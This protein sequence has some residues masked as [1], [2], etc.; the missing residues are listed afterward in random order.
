MSVKV[1]GT[2]ITATRGDTVKLLIGLY[3][4]EGNKYIPQ[5]GDSIRFAMKE[6]YNDPEPLIEKDIPID[7]RILRIDPEDTKNLP[8]P[9][10]YVYD[11]QITYANGEVDTFIDRAK[12]KLTEEVE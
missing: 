12:F 5:E 1:S 9:S 8:Q 11:I 10:S 2:T 6:D 4:H 7:T 3:D